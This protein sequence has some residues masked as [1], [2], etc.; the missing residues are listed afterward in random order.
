MVAFSGANSNSG[1]LN[2]EWD[3]QALQGDQT[4]QRDQGDQTDQTDQTD[5]INQTDQ[6]NIPTGKNMRVVVREL[7]LSISSFDHLGLRS[8]SALAFWGAH[9]VTGVKYPV[10]PACSLSLLKKP[11]SRKSHR[12][13]VP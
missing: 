12:F 8:F 13:E 11:R 6:T 4:D 2:G 3:D 7:S 10:C 5:Q 1:S 9:R